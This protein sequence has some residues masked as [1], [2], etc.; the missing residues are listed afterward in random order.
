MEGAGTLLQG[1]AAARDGRVGNA[2]HAGITRVEFTARCCRGKSHSGPRT[3]ALHDDT[4]KCASGVYLPGIA[5]VAVAVHS[6]ASR[7]N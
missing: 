1:L 4:Q 3:A 7:D 2:L 5:L 6:A